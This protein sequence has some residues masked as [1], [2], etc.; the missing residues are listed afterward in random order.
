MAG[1][2]K[3][4]TAVGRAADL[5]YVPAIDGLRCLAVLAVLVYHLRPAR[6]PGGFTGVDLFFVISGFV[7]TASVARRGFPN[8]RALLTYFY[9]RRFLR[10]LPALFAMLVIVALLSVL[11]IPLVGEVTNARDVAVGASFGASNIVLAVS[12]FEY[13][14]AS[15]ARNPLLHTWTLGVE[16][17]FYLLFPALYWLSLRRAPDGG[18]ILRAAPV[19]LVS[20]LSLAAAAAWPPASALDRFYMMPPRLWE[21][22]LGMLLL[23]TMPRWLPLLKAAPTAI[24]WGAFAACTAALLWSFLRV[25]LDAMPFPGAIPAV[26]ASA[27]LIALVCARPEM[28]PSRLLA[29]SPFTFVGRIS[30]SLYLWHWPVI[31]LLRWTVGIDQ[32]LTALLAVMLSFAMATGS[33]YLV[34]LRFR[35]PAP[36]A[37]PS[38]GRTV[39]AGLLAAAACAALAALVFRSEPAI[40]LSRYA[41]TGAALD[42][43]PEGCRLERQERSLA[44][45]AAWA[46]HPRCGGPATAPRLVMLGDSHAR[47]YRPIL[48]RYAAET[49]AVVQLYYHAACDFPSMRWPLSQR[50][51]CQRF[52]QAVMAELG[53]R[54]RPG[55]VVYMVSMHL[56]AI[57]SFWAGPRI[58]T[59]AVRRPAPSPPG[60]SREEAL[61]ML[62]PLAARGAV[63][64][65][66]LPKPIF[67]SSPFACMDWFNRNNMLCAG[68]FTMRREE[69]VALRRPAVAKLRDVARR[70]P[71]AVVAD[72]LPILCPGAVCSA[73]AG[74]KPLFWDSHHVSRFGNDRLYPAFRALVLSA[75]Q[76][77]RAARPPGRAARGSAR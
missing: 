27:G 18:A 50:P 15:S 54:I 49:G 3:R 11:F 69:I 51:R 73:F 38:G 14:A 52:Y 12:S 59:G 42:R 37:G 25:E 76:T 2:E 33:Y 10:I 20:L 66:E 16:E 57:D 77:A 56:D 6:L 32:R 19:A 41:A 67:R 21:L 46:R 7:V 24:A 65:F 47:Y 70:L 40:S 61:A 31:V 53:G 58:L 63:L 39:I 36:A 43:A 48:E 74:D 13:F 34:E 35:R 60:Q 64:V 28:A 71:R 75:G 44:G 22:G 68:G 23:I 55:D 9:A 1:P 29:T 4:L 5:G 30:Y 62:A 8:V 45:G 72:P 26:A 17:Q